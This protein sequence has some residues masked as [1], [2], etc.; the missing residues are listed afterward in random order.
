MA[1]LYDVNPQDEQKLLGEITD[2]AGEM[3]VRTL[4]KSTAR[5]KVRLYIS[6]SAIHKMIPKQILV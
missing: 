5:T 1:V 4:Q 2:S 3:F 6:Y